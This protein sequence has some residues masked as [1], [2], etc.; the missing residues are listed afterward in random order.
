M[1]NINSFFSKKDFIKSD[2]QIKIEKIEKVL[3]QFDKYKELYLSGLKDKDKKSLLSALDF[4]KI[5]REELQSTEII[6][7][8]L[9][10]YEK[11][12]YIIKK[13]KTQIKKIK[14]SF[15]TANEMYKQLS[16]KE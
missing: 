3:N 7:K 12:N 10:F 16:K 8:E 15:P 9:F 5:W 11:Y 13:Q 2:R 14:E 4:L 1:I 6:I